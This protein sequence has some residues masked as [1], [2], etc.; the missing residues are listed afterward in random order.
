MAT[1]DFSE[2]MNRR[3]KTYQ[4]EIKEKVKIPDPT[5]VHEPVQAVLDG[6]SDGHTDEA[7]ADL[8]LRQAKE[9]IA[10]KQRLPETEGGML[11]TRLRPYT[12]DEL[13]GA[14]LGL[15]E[16]KKAL[17]NGEDLPAD[18]E[19]AP[20]P[21]KNKKPR[22]RMTEAEAVPTPNGNGESHA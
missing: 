5:G 4:A 17:A 11:R 14:V 18:A 6:S 9:K 19:T 13:A 2:W 22:N 12:K 3:A 8:I 16:I 15:A 7:V 10:T 21:K 1:F 20:E